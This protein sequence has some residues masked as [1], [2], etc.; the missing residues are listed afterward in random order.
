ACG[1]GAA[2]DAPALDSAAPGTPVDGGAAPQASAGA[3]A[4]EDATEE[5]GLD[6]VHDNGMTG[7]RWFVEM[8]SAGA[9]LIDYDG[10]GDQDLY[11]VQGGPIEGDG[12]ARPAG[13]PSDRLYR[14]ELDPALG[15]DSLRFSDVTESAGLGGATGY[16][17]GLATGD[18]DNDGDIDLYLANWG[19]NQLWRNT[20][21]GRFEDVTQ[22]AGE[23]LD[24]PRWSAGASFVDYDR[25]GWLDLMIVN[26][27]AYDT[28]SHVDCHS[29][30]SGRLDY[31]GPQ[32]YPA[33]PDRLLHN[34]GDGSFEDVSAEAGI[35]AAYGPGLGVV[36]ADLDGDGWQDLFVANDG[37]E[38]QQWMN[39]GGQ[40]F[41]DRAPAMGSALSRDG[42][43]QA[44]MGVLAEDLDGDADIDLFLTHLERETNTLYLNDGRG[45]F[46]DQSRS[47]GLGQASF[48]FTGF[49]VAA[50]DYD[51]DGRLDIM[52]SNGEVRII[53]EQDAAGDPLPLRQTK[54]LFRGLGEARFEEASASAGEAFGVP[55]VGRG[56]AAGDL[57][58]DGD[59]DLLLAHNGGPAWVLRNR[60]GQDAAWLGLRLRGV[61]G[62]DMLGA[63][64]A[65]L[66]A[67]QPRGWRR[68]A[69]DGSYGSARDPRVLYGLGPGLLGAGET[70]EGL[71]VR[72]PDGSV[73][74][75][76]APPPGAYQDLFQGQGRP[77]VAP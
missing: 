42:M 23:G 1:S 54:Q 6:F 11:L 38:N 32:S 66:V 67:G 39:L 62:R 43:T 26:Y 37:A 68:V 73:E 63:Q 12:R 34:R 53:D 36:A 19:P 50:L 15:P 20:G 40:R 71:R 28:Q 13:S 64:T 35:L 21:D 75:F 72:W 47:S 59:T 65:L 52:V 7:R 3:P 14:N 45:F 24:D 22:T 48:A 29:P 17:N 18:Y 46:E 30:R 27:D 16:G 9:G 69:S 74:D 57:D 4:F 41:E 77:A 31:C 8:M 25:D 56:V 76:P 61:A 60:V 49:G 33:Q 5:L 51:N 58:N 70:V 10:D 2:P 55:A 44:S